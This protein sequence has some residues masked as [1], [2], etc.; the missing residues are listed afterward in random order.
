VSDLLFGTL[1]T[2]CLGTFSYRVQTMS[3]RRNRWLAKRVPAPEVQAALIE[4]DDEFRNGPA[5]AAPMIVDGHLVDGRG[6]HLETDSLQDFFDK[7]AIA[8][9]VRVS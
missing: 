5:A 1:L 4:L 7:W 6:K 2:L 9:R 8:A 3:E